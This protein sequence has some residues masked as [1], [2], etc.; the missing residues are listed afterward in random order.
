MRQGLNIF[1]INSFSKT[2]QFNVF[3]L[4]ADM[5]V[6]TSVSSTLR[7][8][9]GNLPKVWKRCDLRSRENIGKVRLIT[10]NFGF[11]WSAVS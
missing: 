2:W 11:S 7:K 4:L 1:F 3:G 5:S 10:K 6:R 8:Q 9:N